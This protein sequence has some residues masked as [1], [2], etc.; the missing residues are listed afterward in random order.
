MDTTEE[1]H[2][3]R[4]LGK[5]VFFLSVG[6][7]SALSLAAAVHFFREEEPWLA[8]AALTASASLWW[9]LFRLGRYH[10]KQRRGPQA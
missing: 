10:A 5:L 4:Q 2:D 9:P 6:L 7:F 3:L 8:G 1:D